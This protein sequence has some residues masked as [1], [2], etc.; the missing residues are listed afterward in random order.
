MLNFQSQPPPDPRGHALDLIRC[1]A[2]RPIRGIITSDDV[3]GTRTHYFHGRTL[4]C[5]DTSCPACTEG[6]PWRWHA[7]VGLFAAG[8]KNHVLFEMTARAVQP[9]MQYRKAYGTLRGCQ[10]S[11]HRANSSH[12]S[13]VIIETASADLEMI[14]LP[15]PPDLLKA[16]SI[17]WNIEF[18]AL[19]I[20]GIN[21]DAPAL[22]VN[23]DHDLKR[24]SLDAL[25]D[26]IKHD[27]VAGNGK[28][29]D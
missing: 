28:K 15:D 20:D 4:P 6:M 7:Y 12:N 3:L 9:L 11:A 17:I 18:P 21:K 27:A 16:L 19:A 26:R 29:T 25:R 24:N 13:K 8:T 1:P 10:L 22:A 5:D 23:E 14:T 2:S